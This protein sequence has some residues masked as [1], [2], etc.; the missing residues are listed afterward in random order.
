MESVIETLTHLSEW[1]GDH[2]PA[3]LTALAAFLT[4]LWGAVRSVRKKR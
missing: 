1:S 2:V 4:V 3:V